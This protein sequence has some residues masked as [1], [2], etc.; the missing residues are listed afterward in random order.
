MR[1]NWASCRR[2]EQAQGWEERRQCF[3]RNRRLV[4]GPHRRWCW[5]ASAAECSLYLPGSH[6]KPPP[7]PLLHSATG[8]RPAEVTLRTTL[9]AGF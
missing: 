1:T 2:G 7:R 4:E 8:T 3:S 5:P 6:P 9:P